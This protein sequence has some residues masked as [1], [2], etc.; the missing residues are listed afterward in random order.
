MNIQE[1]NARKEVIY[2][3]GYLWCP[4]NEFYLITSIIYRSDLNKID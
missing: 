4:P 3:A 2:I 1:M